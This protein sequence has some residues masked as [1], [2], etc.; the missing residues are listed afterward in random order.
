MYIQWFTFTRR[1]TKSDILHPKLS[2]T[3][4]RHAPLLRRRQDILPRAPHLPMPPHLVLRPSSARA[5]A[6]CCAPLLRPRIAAMVGRAPRRP[7]V[8]DSF[9]IPLPPPLRSPL[10]ERHPSSACTAGRWPPASWSDAPPATSRSVSKMKLFE[11]CYYVCTLLFVLLETL[12]TSY[13]AHGTAD[14][15]HKLSLYCTRGLIC[16]SLLQQAP[17]LL[18]NCVKL[19]GSESNQPLF[20]TVTGCQVSATLVH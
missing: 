20:S 2:A 9:L 10:V 8:V 16:V 5:T 3:A 1:S 11:T 17:F 6:S 14:T 19:M 4:S 18:Q 12:A 7:R 15:S 13:Q